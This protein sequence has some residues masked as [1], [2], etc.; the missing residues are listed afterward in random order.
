MKNNEQL[1]LRAKEGDKSAKEQL[2]NNNMGLV[3]HI[4][5]RF[6][7]RGVETE[8]LIQIGSIGLLKAIDNFDVT[9]GV[10]FS[11]YAVPM[12]QG[13]IRRF[14][15][16]DGMIK[17]SRSIKENSFKISKAVNEY[18]QTYG[19]EPTVNMLCEKTGLAKEDIVLAMEASAEVESIYK[20]TGSGD[21]NERFLVD[22]L[23]GETKEEDKIVNRVLLRQLLDTLSGTDKELLKLRYF[24]DKTQVQVAKKLG[25]SQ[26]QVS[27]ME[28]KILMGLRKIASP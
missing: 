7:G 28:K 9:F 25:I 15:R 22:R 17:I 13:E 4:V 8:D 24:E 11:T 2:V 1:L 27:R 16:D 21:E 19:T 23:A 18:V 26:V 6:T 5:R 3:H 20:T 12:I 10:Q 14:M